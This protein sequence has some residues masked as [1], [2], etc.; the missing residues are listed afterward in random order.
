MKM[1][2]DR[3]YAKQEV[4]ETYKV[5]HISKA[6]I[7]TKTFEGE[8]DKTSYIPFLGS[9]R[10]IHGHDI[11]TARK[12]LTRMIEDEFDTLIEASRPANMKNH[13]V[14]KYIKVLDKIVTDGIEQYRVK[15]PKTQLNNPE[16]NA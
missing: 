9:N 10:G 16:E 13:R 7:K 1:F 5:P 12:N 8:T 3:E 4:V 11:E 14:I 6:I 2:D 15:Q